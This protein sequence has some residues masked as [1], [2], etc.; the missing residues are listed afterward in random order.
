LSPDGSRV[1]FISDRSG[2]LQVWLY[3]F[4]DAAPAPLTDFRGALL[5]DPSWSADGKR[6]LITVRGTQ[7][8]GLVEI[9]LAS[10]RERMVSK[11]GEAMLSGGYGPDEGSFLLVTGASSRENQF[12]LLEHAGADDERKMLLARGVEHVELDPALR[13]VYYTKNAERGLFAR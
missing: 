11:P 5:T 12:V 2:A 8:P 10:R 3:D 4:A 6:L 7:N 13:R 1:A 9:D